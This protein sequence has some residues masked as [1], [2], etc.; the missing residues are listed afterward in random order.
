M[1]LRKF[2]PCVGKAGVWGRQPSI[3]LEQL[4]LFGHCLFENSLYRVYAGIP[5]V[6][7]SDTWVQG[8]AAGSL[9]VLCRPGVPT[10]FDRCEFRVFAKRSNVGSTGGD[11]LAPYSRHRMCHEESNDDIFSRKRSYPCTFRN[12]QNII[13]PLL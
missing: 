8:S 10:L 1:F 2:D 7:G 11:R 12:L 5:G 3:G 13:L 4:F 6:R 9:W